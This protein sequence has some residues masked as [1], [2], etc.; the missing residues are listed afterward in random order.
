LKQ[1]AG[2]YAEL[3]GLLA[4]QADERSR[5]A[6]GAAYIQ[7]AD[8]T[9]K[10]GGRKE[11]LAV[12]RQAL[13]LRRELAAEPGAGVE[14]RLDVARSLQ[15]V[16]GVL[17]ATKD[18][19]GALAAYE[20]ER[21][22]AARL[23][24]ETPTDTVR[25]VLGLSYDR[26]AYLLH[27]LGKSEDALTTKGKALA[28]LRPLAEAHPDV[29]EFQRNLARCYVNLGMIQWQAGRPMEA[30]ESFQR[31]MPILQKLVDA[32]PA[33]PEFRQM[34]ARNHQSLGVIQGQA[35]QAVESLKSCERSIA[36][37][38][39]LVE[40]NRAVAS[41]QFDLALTHANVG[42]TRLQLGQSSEAR[43][44]YQHALP[45][46]QKLVDANPTVVRFQMLLALIDNNLGRLLARE[47][48]FPAGL[49]SFDAGLAIR[50]KLVEAEPKNPQWTRDLGFSYGWRGAAR[51]AAG[52]PALAA[53]DLRHA[54]DVWS[55]NMGNEAATYFEIAKALALLAGL[56]GDAQSGVTAA[57]ARAFGDRAV[58]ALAD[59]IKAGWRPAGLDD[60]KGPEFDALRHR[61]DFKKLLAELAQQ[62]P[63]KPKD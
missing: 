2:F 3:Q 22:I 47:K 28:I 7:L 10:I 61:E 24:A 37:L 16:G 54:V 19:A 50:Q 18:K 30:A 34:L 6:L 12:Y 35:G 21:D 9:D 26:I 38:Q 1:A 62:A 53:A 48:Q 39:G 43:E 51:L 46:A 44:S 41:F 40:A 59:A 5:R 63:A 55:G 11:A 45:V 8:L 17:E 4:G 60:P 58:A 29:A 31:A 33:V 52:Q 32:H 13:A 14:A 15:G 27:Q 56:G 23:E 20:E 25:S 49:A 36:L 42:G 57:E